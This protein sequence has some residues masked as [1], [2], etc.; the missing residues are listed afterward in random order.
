MKPMARH[1]TSQTIG[2]AFRLTKLKL[3]ALIIFGIYAI[4]FSS[5]EICKDGVDFG[6]CIQYHGFPFSTFI[7]GEIDNIP[8]QHYSEIVNV[9][10]F[11]FG[12]VGNLAVIYFLLSC[13]HLILLR[14]AHISK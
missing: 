7:S 2:R 6:Y 13:I 10:K 12:I 14:F 8:S 9:P 3:I 4:I 5:I 11:T 1:L